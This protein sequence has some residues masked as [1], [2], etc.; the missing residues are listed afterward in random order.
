MV[1]YLI[2]SVLRENIH[3]Y[4]YIESS[5]YSAADGIPQFV[6][7]I[8]AFIIS[9]DKNSKYYWIDFTTRV[10]ENHTKTRVQLWIRIV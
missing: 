10:I 7:G 2:I 4:M 3:T 6:N 1:L 5:L 9:M 8:S